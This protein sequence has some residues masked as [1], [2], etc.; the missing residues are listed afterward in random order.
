M[1]TH[2]Q[3]CPDLADKAANTTQVIT[4]FLAYLLGCSALQQE[5]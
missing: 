1:V 4:E 5:A 2:K 3:N